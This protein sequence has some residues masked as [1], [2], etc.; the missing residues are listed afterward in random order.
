MGNLLTVPSD[1]Y[2]RNPFSLDRSL[3][4]DGGRNSQVDRENQLTEIDRLDSPK[5]LHISNIP[6]RWRENELMKLFEV[7]FFHCLLTALSHALL[8]CNI[9]YLAYYPCI[10][11]LMACFSHPYQKYGEVLDKEIIY[12]DRGS[13]VSP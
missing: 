5:R 6:F 12:N 3:P 10:L 2:F 9:T 7:G 13:K 11:A 8:I 4:T 1:N